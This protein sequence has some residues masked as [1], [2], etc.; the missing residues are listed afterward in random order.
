MPTGVPYAIPPGSPPTLEESEALTDDAPG[1]AVSDKLAL[2]ARTCENRIY[3]LS[4][5]VVRID[6]CGVLIEC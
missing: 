5:I 1:S 6:S 2:S 3:Y 4:R